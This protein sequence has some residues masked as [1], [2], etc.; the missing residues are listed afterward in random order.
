MTLL[1]GVVVTPIVKDEKIDLLDGVDMTDNILEGVVVM[2]DDLKGA[3]VI[4]CVNDEKYDLWLLDVPMTCYLDPFFLGRDPTTNST[5][6]RVV[7]LLE[8]L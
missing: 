4:D 5:I 2:D 3:N 1:E 6:D 7:G 8:S